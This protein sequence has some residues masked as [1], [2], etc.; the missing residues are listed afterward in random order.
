MRLLALDDPPLRLGRPSNQDCLRNLRDVQ[1]FAGTG[2]GIRLGPTQGKPTTPR[3]RE[4]SQ[5]ATRQSGPDV[6]TW[7]TPAGGGPSRYGLLG[8]LLRSFRLLILSGGSGAG[9]YKIHLRG[10]LLDARDSQQCRSEFWGCCVGSWL[11]DRVVTRL[12]RIL[13]RSTARPVRSPRS[14]RAKGQALAS[15]DAA[16]PSQSRPTPSPPK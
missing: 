3:I 9:P 8:A 10:G 1:R 14:H 15:S 5:G 13:L 12:G 6:R 4:T 7:P 2:V 16:L 11:T